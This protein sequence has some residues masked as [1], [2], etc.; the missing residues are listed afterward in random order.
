MAMQLLLLFI[1]AML[2]VPHFELPRPTNM[3]VAIFL[4]ALG[5]VIV[6]FGGRIDLT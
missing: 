1:L 2:C 5:I 3:V 4:L 6:L